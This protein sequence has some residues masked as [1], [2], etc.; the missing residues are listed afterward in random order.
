M[1]LRQ[2]QTD[3]INEIRV[4]FA[5]GSNRVILC[6]PT[7][8]GKTIIFS[9]IAELVTKKNNKVLIATDRK[10]LL[11]QTGNKLDLFNVEFEVIK[12]GA[13]KIPETKAVVCMLETLKIRLKQSNYV[14]FIQ[15]FD[16]I[17]IDEAH[18]CSFD[19]IFE[20]LKKD[21]KVIGATATPYR[22]GN[23]KPLKNY[24]DSIVEVIKISEL[25]KNGFLSMPKSYGIK[26]DLSKIKTKMGDYDEYQL[27]SYYQ[28]REVFDG[29]GINYKKY[30][31]NKKAL[32]FC[33]SIENSKTLTDN[34]TAIGLNAKHLDSTMTDQDRTE[35]LT[36]FENTWDAILS[37]VGILTTGFDCPSVEVVILYRATKSLP[38]FLQMVGRGSRTTEIK[39]EFIIL[40][41]GNNIFEHDFWETDRTWTLEIVKKEKTNKK[42]QVSPVK[43]CPECECLIQV[44]SQTCPFCGYKYAKPEKT[45]I[46]AILEQLTPSEVN[47]FAN[48]CTVLEMEEI[49][50]KMGYKIGW[51]LHKLQNINEFR[52]Y[53]KLKGYKKG[54]A[55]FN[56]KRYN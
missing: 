14:D 2:Y 15:S 39:K 36:W 6:A 30:C 47:K 9:K 33:V 20:S 21:Q 31:K 50:D 42:E 1:K 51:I 40:D 26:Q 28:K 52:E 48:E 16:L 56:F 54:W 18:K 10:E 19:R 32:I 22:N 37:N 12:A 43:T 44:S 8:A 7:G 55:E 3:A 49:R 53:E 13:R 27:S 25:I 41:F 34:L 4:E 5:K 29:V 23:M 38:L 46:E 35:I 17:I 11:T 45:K 24:Y